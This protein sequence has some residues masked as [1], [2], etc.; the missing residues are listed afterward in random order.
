MPPTTSGEGSVTGRKGERLD[1]WLQLAVLSAFAL[2]Q[3]LFAVVTG[4]ATFFVAHH[5]RPGDLVALALVVTLG[6][7]VVFGC[8][9][10]LVGLAGRAARRATHAT[11]VAALLVAL[12]LAPLSRIESL[13]EAV[14]LSLVLLVAG[15]GTL[16]LMHWAPA[17]AFMR[18]LSPAPLVFA[19]LFL[20][21][22]QVGKLLAPT[23]AAPITR[24]ATA[25]GA[26]PPASVLLLLV[27]ELPTASLL[28]TEGAIDA[29]LFPNFAR[30][31]AD[32]TWCR[33]ASSV[34]SKTRAAIPAILT[35]VYPDPV[36]EKLPIAQDHP[37]NLLSL[38]APTHAIS[39]RES[40]TA[41]VPAAL[42][43]ADQRPGA[44]TAQRLGALARDVGVVWAHVLLPASFA[45]DLPPV[46][47][48]WRDFDRGGPATEAARPAT[49]DGQ[50]AGDELLLF[51]ALDASTRDREWADKRYSVS[52]D[53]RAFV[54]TL[55][56]ASEPTA[57]LFHTLLPHQPW[58]H[59]DTGQLYSHSWRMPGRV[60]SSWSPVRW[61]SSLAYQR[62]LLQVCHLD[63]LLGELLDALHAHDLYDDMLLVVLAD[64]GVS[65]RPGTSLRTAAKDNADHILYVPFFVK[66]PGQRTPAT[67][68]RNVELIDVLPTVADVLG[69][70]VP[71]PV[72]GSSVF[73]AT[74]E[75]PHKRLFRE[76]GPPLTLSADPPQ[77]WEMV[78][79][80][81]E[82]FGPSPQ[83]SDLYAMGPWRGVIGRSVADASD[84]A[85]GGLRA[86]I[87]GAHRYEDVDPDAPELP[88]L[89]SGTVTATA[90]TAF[91]SALAIAVNG[92]VAAV[93]YPHDATSLTAEFSVVIPA[94][95]LRPGANDIAVHALSGTPAAP[96]FQSLE[97]GAFALDGR[98]MVFPDGRRLPIRAV[99]RRAPAGGIL[100]VDSKSGSLTI[101]GWAATR[102]QVGS[103]AGP[104]QG[105]V[106]FEDDRFVMAASPKKANQSF[107]F[108]I[109]LAQ[110]RGDPT[111][112]I[113]VLSVDDAAAH[114]LE[115]TG[116]AAWIFAP[117]PGGSAGAPSQRAP[118]DG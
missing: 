66:R 16:A 20:A 80:R 57:S 41:M 50:G 13:P 89:V 55:G 56:P 83:R 104:S 33:N 82:L 12:V 103:D 106:V 92:T 59:L 47:I 49:G 29:R 108:V 54:A 102:P 73:S 38:L 79:R 113:T 22:E 9:L 36:Y 35:G 6:P 107:R 84:L 44:D 96:R 61:L 78:Q 7:P 48:G 67:T 62:H 26:A 81:T 45:T 8:A 37:D 21:D 99:T 52:E 58:I 30:L 32:S 18:V 87:A 71:F 76:H 65:F 115:G 114:A 51:E 28:N 15:L 86:V 118:R 23:D 1:E 77:T 31:A 14:T 24:Q 3:P 105:V 39:A 68:E 60:G 88:C 64:H 85:L 11:F 34:H 111:G 53:F 97:P 46:D 72:D 27:D 98:D 74:D 17:A 93:T 2:A 95:R 100:Q 5:A 40:V 75:R 42:L 10:A 4:G 69:L 63:T 94:S 109:P 25:E 116:D 70:P 112:R 110:L 90:G 117:P 91:P 101:K 43:D 19:A